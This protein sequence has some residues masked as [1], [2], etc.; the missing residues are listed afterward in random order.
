MESSS[1]LPVR[2]QGRM[3]RNLAQRQVYDVRSEYQ[4]GRLVW[5]AHTEFIL[6]ESRVV[7]NGCI[8]FR[9][10]DRHRRAIKD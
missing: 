4:F 1:M 5:S 2:L 8:D 7:A 3:N 6:T 9:E 10:I